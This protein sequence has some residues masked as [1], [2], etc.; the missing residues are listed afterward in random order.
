MAIP[1]H[2]HC[3]QFR[4]GL[5]TVGGGAE[6]VDTVD[7][8]I[9]DVPAAVVASCHSALVS[10][11]AWLAEQLDA[12]SQASLDNIDVEEFRVQDRTPIRYWP[13]N[14]L[15]S[16]QSCPLCASNER[17]MV[18]SSLTD[19]IFFCAPGE[20]TLY[21]CLDCEVGYLDPRPSPDT[22]SLA[23]DS[24]YTH[25][26]AHK[27]DV[28]ELGLIQKV[29]RSMA[30]GYRNYR[31][32]TQDRPASSLGLLLMS[33]PKQRMSID[34]ESRHMPRPRPGARLLDIGCG[35]G[36]FLE[37]AQRAGWSVVGVDFDK[38]AV[39]AARSRGLDIRHGG[40]DVIDPSEQFDGITLSHVIEHVHDP[41]TLLG[42][43]HRLLKPGGWIWLETPNLN[44]LGHS[45]YGPD[46]RGLEPPRH[47]VLFTPKS[48]K[49]SLARVGF[50]DMRIEPV[51]RAC[52]FTFSASE[53][54][55]GGESSD[56][57][58]SHVS[59]VR[60]RIRTAEKIAA[61][62]PAVREFITMKAWKSKGSD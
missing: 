3:P 60:S 61:N 34:A 42:L 14:G 25:Q 21:R 20:W 22:I 57:K 9:G 13:E 4:Y 41:L 24:Y 54:I 38:K 6:A 39:D 16:V 12:L 1:R 51:L 50:R 55:A 32:G 8:A 46:W 27:K 31:F 58:G 28:E 19:R 33:L 49:Q 43:C 18:H 26:P 62:D 15:E 47:L 5:T 59:R 52:E 17:E 53:A 40:A 10:F 29:R 23:Y 44:S 2:P 36:S 7:S 37:F 11:G 56:Q 48:M 35:D 45:Y 30:N